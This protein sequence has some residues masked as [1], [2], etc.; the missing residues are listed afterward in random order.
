MQSRF[1]RIV[2]AIFGVVA[3]WDTFG[4]QLTPPGVREK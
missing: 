1:A 2:F 3:A 4:S